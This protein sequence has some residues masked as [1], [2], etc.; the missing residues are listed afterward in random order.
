MERCSPGFERLLE[1][2]PLD[3]L[4]RHAG[5]VYGMWA[6][7]SLAYFNPAWIW[8]AHENGADPRIVSE[9]YLGTS[10]LD[11]TPDG[12]AVREILGE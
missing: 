10:M 5:T 11:V 3:E 4:E 8:F 6:D 2:F 12:L 1:P 7:F 9:N